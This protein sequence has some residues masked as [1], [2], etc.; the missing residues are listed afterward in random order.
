[1]I[2][3]GAPDQLLAVQW[4]EDVDGLQTLDARPSLSID[5]STDLPRRLIPSRSQSRRRKPSG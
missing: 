5:A 2:H 1:M 3:W 4:S